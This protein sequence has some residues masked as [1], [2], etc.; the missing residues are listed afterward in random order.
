MKKIFVFLLF[1]LFYMTPGTV[2]SGEE[3]YKDLDFKFISNGIQINSVGADNYIVYPNDNCKVLVTGE[4]K[5]NLGIRLILVEKRNLLECV[6]FREVVKKSEDTVFTKQVFDFNLTGLEEDKYYRYDVELFSTEDSSRKKVVFE[7]NVEVH[8]RTHIEAGIGPVFSNL[9]FNKFEVTP[10]TDDTSGSV[11]IR[12]LGTKSQLLFVMGAII[13]PWGYD[14][15]AKPGLE[16]FYLYMGLGINSEQ[17]VIDNL[18]FGIGYGF[19][20]F[21]IVAGMHISKT[22][23]LI[24]RFEEGGIY[25]KDDIGSKENIVTEKFKIGVFGGLL[26]DLSIFDKTFPEIF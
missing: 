23:Q 10:V 21:N 3:P 4:F 5:K 11:T 25:N 13:R 17:T 16:N 14:Q 7:F 24:D 26:I 18:H 8:S 22:L 15:R 19:R 12:N 9:G 2:F 20:G 6:V 1:V